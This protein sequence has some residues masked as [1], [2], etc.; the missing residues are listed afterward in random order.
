MLDAVILGGGIGGYTAAFE[1]SKAGLTTTIVEQNLMGGTCLN[2]GCI[3]TKYLTHLRDSI[4]ESQSLQKISKT[5]IPNISLDYEKVFEEKEAM[6]TR[7]RTA[8]I[9]EIQKQQIKIINGRGEI[10]ASNRIKVDSLSEPLECKHIIIATGSCTPYEYPFQV[11]QP[12]AILNT[13]KILNLKELPK[14]MLI[15]GAGVNGI[16][17]A[18]IFNAFGVKVIVIEIL[19][20]ILPVL[21]T[22]SARYMEIFLKRQ[23]IEILKETK[24][25]QLKTQENGFK[26][27]YEDPKEGEKEIFVE[28]V[29]AC[30]GRHPNSH[31]IGLEHVNI[32]V[33][34][35]G[36]IQVSPHLSTEQKNIYAIGDTIASPALAHQARY[37]GKIAAYNIL[38]P[39][40]PKQANNPTP[41]V[42]FCHPEIATIGLNEDQAKEKNIDYRLIRKPFGGLGKATAI[43]ATEGTARLL[44]SDNKIIGATL[45]GKYA[46]EMINLFTLATDHNIPLSELKELIIPHPTMSEI[47]DEALMEL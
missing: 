30:T 20:H 6:I 24:I 26:V 34:T 37:E 21:D 27:V 43:K 14:S 40:N 1:L 17:M 44:I 15:V 9:K 42:I 4:M 18:S 2:R 22:A 16:E 5:S 35:K 39:D 31:Q 12:E 41:G 25:H 8:L 38:H 32:Q 3:P 29:L 33:D 7:L 19:P 23:G 47:I 45:I 46:A 11:D 36:F 10:I 13:D 28:S